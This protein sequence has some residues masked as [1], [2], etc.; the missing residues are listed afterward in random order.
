[1]L[2]VLAG[3][4]K[5]DIDAVLKAGA[6]GKSLPWR[7]PKHSHSG[8]SVLFYLPGLGFTARG[9]IAGE[10]VSSESELGRYRARVSALGMARCANE[11]LYDH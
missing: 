8:D 11:K 2:H 5:A 1:M 6:N 10:P 4:A 3:D 7:V 9:V